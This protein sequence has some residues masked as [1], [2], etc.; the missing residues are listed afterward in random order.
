[1]SD[2]DSAYDSEARDQFDE[3]FEELAFKQIWDRMDK[4]QQQLEYIHNALRL[5]IERLERESHDLVTGVLD[6]VK[7][8]RPS[9]GVDLVKQNKRHKLL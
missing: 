9:I 2:V 8:K 7:K 5:R 1:M 4:Y 6:I 3:M